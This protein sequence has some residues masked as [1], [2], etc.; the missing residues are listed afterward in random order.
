M[1]G[2]AMRTFSALFLFI[3]VLAAVAEPVSAMPQGVQGVQ[4]VQLVQQQG[5]KPCNAGDG[6]LSAPLPSAAVYRL[7]PDCLAELRSALNAGSFGRALEIY[8][9][10]SYN[11]K[12]VNWVVYVRADGSVKQG[13]IQN[14]VVT[15]LLRGQKYIYAAAFFEAVPTNPADSINPSLE[16]SRRS[17]NFTK[18]Q[19]TTV[20]VNAFGAGKIPTFDAGATVGDLDRQM[21]LRMVSDDP[22]VALWAG[23]A[24]V[25]IG[26]NTDVQLSLG[27][28]GRQRL[29]G[30]L[31]RLYT[32]VNNAKATR[33]DLGLGIASSFGPGATTFDG[34]SEKVGSSLKTNIYLTTYLNLLPARL[35][36]FRRSWSIVGGTNIANGSLL[37]DLLTGVAVGRVVGDAGLMTGVLWETR[38]R[39]S[40]DPVTHANRS[41]EYRQP[42]FFIGFDLRA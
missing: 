21:S 24:R 3:S 22:R 13:V 41:S 34:V 16:L 9:G 38:K 35:P 30:T 37:D 27:A 29:P 12:L 10:D 19:F 1:K 18:D 2:L 7:T 15:D 40:V 5:V 33:W 25:E 31:S 11:P 20:L 17:I 39:D 28:N 6:T 26:E 4:G 8:F 14:G 42:R 36:R 32:T 23:S